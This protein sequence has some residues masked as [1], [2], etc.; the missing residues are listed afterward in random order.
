[1]SVQAPGWRNWLDARDLKSLGGDPIRVRVSA[2]ALV[3]TSDAAKSCKIGPTGGVVEL[4]SFNLQIV[5][6]LCPS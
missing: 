4:R 2:P 3:L 6:E 5:P 1:M